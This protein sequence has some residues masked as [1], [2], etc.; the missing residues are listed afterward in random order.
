ML[1]CSR[2]ILAQYR[3]EFILQQRL[4]RKSFALFGE[5]A[6]RQIQLIPIE[7]VRNVER[8]AWAKIELH[9]RS[10]F[11]DARDYWPDQYVRRIIIDSN[12]KVPCRCGWIKMRRLERMLQTVKRH[13]DR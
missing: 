4:T 7:Q 6:D 12:P 3:D 1:A 2:V 9:L 11:G 5:S 13:P 8:A 10:N